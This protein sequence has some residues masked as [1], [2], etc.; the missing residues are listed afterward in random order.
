MVYEDEYNDIITKNIRKLA[1]EGSEGLPVG[2][3]LASTPYN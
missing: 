1:V 3:Q 2:V